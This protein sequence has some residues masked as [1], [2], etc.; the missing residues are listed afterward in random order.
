MAEITLV[1]VTY[2]DRW[3]VLRPTI[4]S[5][6]SDAD[7][8]VIVVDNGSA[9]PSRRELERFRVTNSD[10]VSVVTFSRN[11]GSATAFR[12]G[13]QAAYA[14]D[15]PI[16]LLDDDTPIPGGSIE[17][18]SIISA[19]LAGDVVPT[20]LAMYRPRNAAQRSLVQGMSAAEVFKELRPGAFHGFDLF[21]RLTRPMMVST[22]G[23]V[24]YSVGDE[25]V[26]HELPSAMW[27]G[28]Y[29]SR[30]AARLQILP[31]QDLVLYGDDNDFSDKIRAAGAALYLVENIKIVDAVEWRPKS[32][33]W[34]RWV[35]S[36]FLTPDSEVWRLQYLHRNQSFLS[37][38]R[39]N[40]PGPVSRLWVNA[41]VRLGGVLIVAT[42]MGRSK[43]GVQLVSASLRGLRR[44]LGP[45]YPLPQSP[46]LEPQ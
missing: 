20:G 39:A 15:E 4:E 8:H 44:R 3:N 18:L 30:A 26:L 17:K 5:V 35:P 41:T 21:G 9:A 24:N 1:T 40:G 22:G 38:Q 13:L 29:L 36:T 11:L 42:L 46:E 19:G 34:R 32:Q 27:G 16:L 7:A 31:N 2:G 33:G 12:S 14:R 10:R 23:K 25:Y 43:L 45:A 28:L 6:I 37:R